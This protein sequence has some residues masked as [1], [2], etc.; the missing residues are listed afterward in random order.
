MD[1]AA[2]GPDGERD[3]PSR[4]GSNVWGALDPINQKGERG[5]HKLSEGKP[6]SF[7]KRE[8]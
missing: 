1:K 7:P 8:A 6:G 2:R 4:P 5:K 3:A